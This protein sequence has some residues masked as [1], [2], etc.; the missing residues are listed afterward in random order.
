MVSSAIW[1]KHAAVNFSK[2]M[3]KGQVLFE[4]FEKLASACLIQISQEAILFN[5]YYT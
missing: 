2:S 5:M 4:V 1:T 3:S